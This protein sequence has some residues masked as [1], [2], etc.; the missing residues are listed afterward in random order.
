MATE[1]R[2]TPEQVKELMDLLLDG[3]QLK[4]LAAYSEQVFGLKISNVG[5]HHWK[6]YQAARK[7]L[8]QKRRDEAAEVLDGSL[9]Q[10]VSALAKHM[11]SLEEER[12]KLV[13]DLANNK[14]RS[15]GPYSALLKNL[16][17]IDVSYNNYLRQYKDVM[18][19]GAGAKEPI[20]V[21]QK[22]EKAES[23]A[24]LLAELKRKNEAIAKPVV[25]EEDLEL[26]N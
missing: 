8:K 6:E 10:T 18:A 2:H 14:E 9:K 1:R 4:E 11:R 17:I 15:R 12:E 19:I 13:N 16:S 26:P 23:I 25:E 3:K 22:S 21:E 7:A 24:D 20:E 5:I